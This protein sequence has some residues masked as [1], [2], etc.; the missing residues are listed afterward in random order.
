MEGK[1]LFFNPAPSHIGTFSKWLGQQ[2]RDGNHRAIRRR[3]IVAVDVAALSTPTNLENIQMVDLLRAGTVWKPKSLTLLE[4]SIIHVGYDA[5]VMDLM[6]VLSRMGKKTLLV[7]FDSF[8]EGDRRPMP[9]EVRLQED[10]GC[11]MHGQA[12]QKIG[13]DFRRASGTTYRVTMPRHHPSRQRLRQYLQARLAACGPG[14]SLEKWV[15]NFSTED[16]GR[17]WL[18]T[19]KE[20][21]GGSVL[22]TCPEVEFA[23][24]KN[25][26]NLQT[27]GYVEAGELMFILQADWVEMVGHRG[28]RYEYRFSSPAYLKDLGAHLYDLNRMRTEGKKKKGKLLNTF[29]MLSTD[30][31]L[32]MWVQAELKPPYARPYVQRIRA[33]TAITTTHKVTRKG[34][35]FS[36][37]FGRATKEKLLLWVP[38][39]TTRVVKQGV[40]WHGGGATVWAYVEDELEI[41]RLNRHPIQALEG[42]EPLIVRQRTVVPGNLEPLRE[43]TGGRPEDEVSESKTRDATGLRFS[44]MTKKLV[45]QLRGTIG[46]DEVLEC[47]EPGRGGQGKEAARTGAS[48]AS[49]RGSRR[50]RDAGAQGRRRVVRFQ[51]TQEQWQLV[52]QPRGPRT[53][54]QHSGGSDAADETEQQV[55]SDT[56]SFSALRNPGNE[57]DDEESDEEDLSAAERQQE[58]Q[59]QRQQ[60]R[61]P[62]KQQEPTSQEPAS[63]QGQE[64]VKGGDGSPEEPGEGNEKHNERVPLTEKLG[65]GESAAGRKAPNRAAHLEE[66]GGDEQDEE[67]SVVGQRDDDDDDDDDGALEVVGSLGGTTTLGE[68]STVTVP[69]ETKIHP[70]FGSAQKQNGGSRKRSRSVPAPG[71]VEGG[72]GNGASEHRQRFLEL[73]QEREASL[74]S[75]STN[76][77]QE[78]L[79]E[80]S[81]QESNLPLSAD[82]KEKTAPLRSNSE[83]SET[84]LRSNSERIETP[85]NADSERITAPLRLNSVGSNTPLKGSSESLMVN[86]DL[87]NTTEEKEKVVTDPVQGSLPATVSAQGTVEEGVVRTGKEIPES[88]VY[89][90]TR[91][92]RQQRARQTGGGSGE[93]NH[94][95]VA[96]KGSGASG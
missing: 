47:N 81:A 46:F 51:G 1:A 84:P 42:R 65:G 28:N 82:S 32:S 31:G 83:R 57:D 72:G 64:V 68:D 76:A 80:G 78:M 86:S 13:E 18:E 36:L 9:S 91:G 14:G 15:V 40:V 55:E 56:N 41:E 6:P 19:N 63:G 79:Q 75:S 70:F 16:E 66:A 62:G 58:Q 95:R 44:A 34:Q 67:K 17:S 7:E 87:Q 88:P 24:G 25:V 92:R 77:S 73:K 33:E 48:M 45:E 39:I 50:R 2:M 85:L 20:R 54:Q 22:F 12:V 11:Y 93:Q 23:G 27:K 5:R 43:Q 30:E 49:G 37:H 21:A 10:L 59:K 69:D 52:G 60:R 96:R 90:R 74:L 4:D 89:S 94:K 35:W 8:F 61:Q 26:K 53:R 3:A 29:V 38:Q 71:E